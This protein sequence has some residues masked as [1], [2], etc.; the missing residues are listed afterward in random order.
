MSE[1]TTNSPNITT[2]MGAG[3]AVGVRHWFVACV[4]PNTE[5]ASRD[6]LTQMGY[7][8]FVATQEEVKFWKNGERKK[9]KKVERV[10]ITQYVFVHVTEKERLEIVQQP[11]IRFFMMDR[12]KEKRSIAT[13]SE[14]EMESL[15]LMLGKA[16]STVL[17]ASA[18]YTI[19]EEVI[20]HFGN[21]D[22]KARIVRIFGDKTPY[23]GVRLESL[24]CAYMEMS[25]AEIKRPTT[26]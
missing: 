12:S 6:R 10:V 7:E 19:G 25:L 18:G 17:F 23:V 9:R 20:A 13:I 24:G 15:K 4:K 11:F 26:L 16:D 8:T 2:A 5:K 22:Y 1:M 3:D 14:Q 21:Y